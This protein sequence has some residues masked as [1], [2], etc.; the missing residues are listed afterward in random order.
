MGDRRSCNDNTGNNWVRKHLIYP[1]CKTDVW[2][3][4]FKPLPRIRIDLANP[5]KNAQVVEISDEILTPV[6]AANT[7]DLFSNRVFHFS[8]EF[9]PIYSKTLIAMN[10]GFEEQQPST[11]G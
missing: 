7:G 4:G 2:V 6:S 8:N 3:N 11:S 10:A 1:L 9:L 5:R